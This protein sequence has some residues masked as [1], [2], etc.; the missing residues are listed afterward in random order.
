[1]YRQAMI[2]ANLDPVR[3]CVGLKT[4]FKLGIILRLKSR[5]G[6]AGF[7]VQFKSEGQEG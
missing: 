2:I 5:Q 6:T 1:M 3:K 7:Y 4:Y